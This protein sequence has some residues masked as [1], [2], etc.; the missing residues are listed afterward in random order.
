MFPTPLDMLYINPFGMSVISGV[1][2][3][4]EKISAPIAERARAEGVK[5]GY[6]KASN[7]YEGKLRSQAEEFLKQI[8]ALKD[9]VNSLKNQRDRAQKIAK[10]AFT[11]LGE[12]EGC[13]SATQEQGH[14]VNDE[15]REY[16]ELLK[17]VTL[18]AV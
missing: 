8:T 1:I 4:L 15:T 5:E 7:E 16:Y 17:K 9:D 12:F 2:W 13:I 6:S 3:A 10:K 11:L 18:N 14:D